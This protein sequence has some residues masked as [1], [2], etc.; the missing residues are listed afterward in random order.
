MISDISIPLIRMSIRR[1]IMADET[2]QR[3]GEHDGEG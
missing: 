3:Y 2:G 1:Y